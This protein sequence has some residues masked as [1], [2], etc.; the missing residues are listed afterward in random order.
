MFSLKYQRVATQTQSNAL[1][2]F[3]STPLNP[4]RSARSS[5]SHNLALI[6]LKSQTQMPQNTELGSALAVLELK[7]LMN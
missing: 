3:I 4:G 2:S 5:V 1:Y 6:R 7:G